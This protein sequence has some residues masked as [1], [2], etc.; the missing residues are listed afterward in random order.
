MSD[1]RKRQPAKPLRPL[2]EGLERRVLYSA[3]AA[4]LG[5]DAPIVP[6][7]DDEAV[8]A[9][10][11]LLED[12]S[13]E[14]GL[15][16]VDA[17]GEA[18]HL[19]VLDADLE[20]VD[21]L[22]D[23][24]EQGGAEVLLFRADEESAEAVLQRIS[25]VATERGEELDSISIVSHGSGG[26]FELGSGLV[27]RSSAED[28]LDLWKEVGNHLAADGN[29]YLYGCNIV[30]GSGEGQALLDT[31]AD[32][33]GADVFASSDLSGAGGDWDLEASSSGDE[34]EA[35]VGLAAPIEA[36]VI[37]GMSSALVD[38]NETSWSG[39]QVFN[40]GAIS[41]T[42]S[43]L[44]GGSIDWH[45]DGST[46]TLT[47]TDLNGGG[48]NADFEIIDH[49]GGLIVDHISVENFRGSLTSDVDIGT[50]DFGLGNP[51]SLIVGGG[52]GSIGTI[53]LTGPVDDSGTIQANV[54]TIDISG[55][56]IDGGTTIR[57]E[58]HVGDVQIDGDVGAGAS[59]EVTGNLSTLDITGTAEGSVDVDGDMTSVD[60]GGDLNGT[61]N[62]GG[63]LPSLTVVGGGDATIVVGGDLDVA[64]WGGNFVGTLTVTNT[65]GDIDI[66]DDG[67]NEYSN[68][69][70]PP[71][72][73]FYD[74]STNHGTPS[75]NNAP[76]ADPVNIVM[77]EDGTAVVTLMGSDI[78]AG[79]AIENFRVV[80]ERR[81]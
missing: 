77:T 34:A 38:Y 6:L 13:T 72:T 9:H 32:A 7:D 22:R 81:Q 19:V 21:L 27:T 29:L 3:D 16:S 55:G 56:G 43:Y 30:D 8:R 68:H 64:S 24:A 36:S 76:T 14:A 61:V 37:E 80:S 40:D 15:E 79:D 2:V 69:L 53:N 47:V 63:D 60:V 50:L 67:I 42:L 5:V 12:I 78:D 49:N 75:P 74:G 1:S 70:T 57:V 48:P 4:A 46:N 73:V 20:D 44:Q 54:G 10:T 62:I 17:A 26:Q 11:Q 65:V 18:F 31:L 51:T 25:G 59:L 52:S 35:I 45:Y 28:S 33:T 66:I 41:F 23:A 71:T 58:G 39:T